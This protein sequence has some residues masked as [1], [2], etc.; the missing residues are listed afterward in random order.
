MK[1]HYRKRNDHFV[2]AVQLNLE[3]SGVQYEKWGGTQQCNAG[4]WIVENQGECYTISADSFAK[5]YQCISPGLYKK[6]ADVTAEQSS[7]SGKV[8]TNEGVTH[9]SAGDYIV[10]NRGD[11]RDSYAVDRKVFEN[12]YVE[13]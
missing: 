2:I 6:I 13:I 4:D 7:E 5:T 3:T 10:Q 9:Y 1:K 11:S 12:M 8:D